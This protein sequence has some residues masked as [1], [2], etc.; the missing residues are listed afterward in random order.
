[1]KKSSWQATRPALANS[2]RTLLSEHELDD[3]VQSDVNL[4]ELLS[5]AVEEKAAASCSSQ[6]TAVG[7]PCKAR[8]AAL[9]KSDS[10]KNQRHTNVAE[11]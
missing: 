8:R 6:L 7:T 11:R 10:C 5:A 1:M 3:R 4:S 9:T 2:V